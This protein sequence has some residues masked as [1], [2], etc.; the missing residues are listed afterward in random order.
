MMKSKNIFSRG[1]SMCKVTLMR[2]SMASMRDGHEASVAR[3][4][5]M[6]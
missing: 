6:R 4:E 5:K 3:P 1:N 2:Q